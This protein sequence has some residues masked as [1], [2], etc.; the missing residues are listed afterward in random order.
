M[1]DAPQAVIWTILEININYEIRFKHSQ[2]FEQV[3]GLLVISNDF[4]S[5][6]KYPRE[7]ARICYYLY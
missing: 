7:I 1:Y 4:D 2:T 5:I 6:N 3:E